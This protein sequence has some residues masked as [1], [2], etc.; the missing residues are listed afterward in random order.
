MHGIKEGEGLIRL[1]GQGQVYKNP[2]VVAGFELLSAVLD[3]GVGGV[4]GIP[5]IVI[6]GDIAV[7]DHVVDKADHVHQGHLVGGDAADDPA[8]VLLVRRIGGVEGLADLVVHVHELGELPGVEGIGQRIV[9]HG[10]GVGKTLAV[11]HLVAGL[12]VLDQLCLIFVAA[13]GQ[14]QGDQVVGAEVVLDHL[15]RDLGR[16]LDRGRQRGVAVDIGALLGQH[17]SSDEEK[18]EHKRDDLSRMKGKVADA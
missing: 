18:E 17:G 9:V 5:Q 8:V 11:V 12:E 7:L 13:M 16:V 1:L 6:E 3:L 2:V 14:D 15:V 10:R 4:Q